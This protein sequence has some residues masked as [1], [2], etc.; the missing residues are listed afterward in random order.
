[1]N[2]W[3]QDRWT[4]FCDHE[5]MEQ[6]RNN[7]RNAKLYFGWHSSYRR[8]RPCLSCCTKISSVCSP[9]DN[10]FFLL[11]R[12]KPNIVLGSWYST[13]HCRPGQS[14]SHSS[15]FERCYD[16]P[17]YATAVTRWFGWKGRFRNHCR[18]QGMWLTDL[19]QRLL[20]SSIQQQQQRHK[21]MIWLVEWAQIIMLKVTCGTHGTHN[22]ST[23]LWR[24]MPN[25]NVKFQIMRFCR[26][27]KPAAVNFSFSV[28]FT[29]RPFVACKGHFVLRRNI[30]RQRQTL[31]F[32][33]SANGHLLSLCK[34]SNFK[35]EIAPRLPGNQNQN[36]LEG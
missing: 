22:V 20:Y 28:F 25:D 19:R 31:L 4:T 2:N 23:F 15:S 6:S 1:M 12:H 18:R 14:E 32:G 10:L 7:R 27:R 17:P 11:L 30:K 36:S 13:G 21:S 35:T 16:A 33:K 3:A 5:D 24:N 26:R 9:T 34:I 29:W 8:H